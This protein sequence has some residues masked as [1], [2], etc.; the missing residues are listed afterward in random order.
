M[1]DGALDADEFAL[2]MH[3]M[4]IKLDGN[5]LPVELPSHLIPPSK[6][7]FW[8]LQT[9]NILHDVNVNNVQTW[10]TIYGYAELYLCGY[11]T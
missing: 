6:R 9:A 1:K 11:I 4:N 5:D 2:A 3:L 8:D 7:G 10:K